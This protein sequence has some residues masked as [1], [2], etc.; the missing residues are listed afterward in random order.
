MKVSHWI[1]ARL[2]LPTARLSAT[3]NNLCVASLLQIVF[4]AVT[5]VRLLFPLKREGCG[6]FG[7]VAAGPQCFTQFPILP[8]FGEADGFYLPHLWGRWP[9]RRRRGLS[10]KSLEP[11]SALTYSR[12]AANAPPLPSASPPGGETRHWPAAL[13]PT[14]LN[15]SSARGKCLTDFSVAFGSLRNQFAYFSPLKRGGWGAL[16]A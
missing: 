3:H 12:F 15:R 7:G 2:R 14:P 16:A 5:P 13:P 10:L 6:C 9:R 4:S 11:A 8:F 1:F